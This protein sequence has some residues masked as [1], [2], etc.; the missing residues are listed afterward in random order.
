MKK[1]LI[2]LMG[3][4]LAEV[5]R[6]YVDGRIDAQTMVAYRRVWQWSAPRFEAEHG[7]LQDAFEMRFGREA[8]KA[9]IDKTRR[10]FGFTPIYSKP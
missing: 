5:V 2:A 1:R 7:L 9:K 10:S 6:L 8:Y 4:S 3:R